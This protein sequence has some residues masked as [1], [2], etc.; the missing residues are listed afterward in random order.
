LIAL[1]AFLTQTSQPP[2]SAF[3]I[4]I[5]PTARGIL[6]ISVLVWLSAILYDIFLKK[7]G[8]KGERLWR[9]IR[10]LL[11]IFA[12]L[13]AFSLSSFLLFG[14]PVIELDQFWFVLPVGGVI[15]GI[16]GLLTI[17]DDLRAP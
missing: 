7:R 15:I 17:V 6:I 12:V 13:S 5:S 3:P 14:W 10:L 16:V 4:I 11:E 2:K 9:Y 1:I 8:F